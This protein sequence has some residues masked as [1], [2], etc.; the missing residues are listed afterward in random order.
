MRPPTNTNTYTRKN[1]SK[2]INAHLYAH[3]KLANVFSVIRLIF[4][5]RFEHLLWSGFHFDTCHGM[6][7]THHQCQSQRQRRQ[8]SY[9]QCKPPKTQKE[10][11]KFNNKARLF[12]HYMRWKFKRR[13]R[14]S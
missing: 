3:G 4:P 5:F 8:Q 12:I 6:E 11:D 7:N 10:Q 2:K 1:V 9:Q 13:C 14:D